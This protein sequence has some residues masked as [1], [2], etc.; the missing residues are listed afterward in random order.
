MKICC[1][2]YLHGSGGAERQ[3]CMLANNLAERGHE[4]CLIVMSNY[5]KRYEINKNVRVIDCASNDPN[6]KFS[7]IY[8]Y[9]AL[10]KI[11]INEKP[12]ITIHYWL[13]SAYLTAFMK[14]SLRGKIIYSERGD[15]GDK[16]YD[17]FLGIIRNL[18]FKKVD[19]FVFQTEG[20][21][22]FF[23]SRI[24]ERSIVIHNSVEIPNCDE[25]LVPC[26][27]RNKI[28]VNVGRLSEQKNQRL[29]IK[30]F[31]RIS[32][33]IPD[34]KLE[35]YGDGPL[36]DE[37]IELINS[38]GLRDKVFLM[39]T[40]KGIHEIMHKASLF[41]LSSD[42]EGMP[43]ALLEAMSL[44]TPSISTDC[45]PGGARSLIQDGYNGWIT[46]VGDEKSLSDTMKYVLTHR[47]EAEKASQ[48]A[49]RIRDTHTDISVYNK[50]D[51]YI[52]EIIK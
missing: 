20:A 42:Y 30:A 39:G 35:I 51:T 5:N 18:A 40:T 12:D 26:V 38:N 28:I 46:P 11:Y 4:V 50:W 19:G 21:Q 52:N 37:L 34:Y 29:L 43:N 10:K 17:G 14:K 27:D 49:M 47:S 36:K 23:D 48:C 24:K 32:P 6:N 25:F 16:E 9:K 7:I 45:R 15:P 44:G 2:G 1:I 13:Q 22:N 3:I 8:R 41:V 33:E 31:A